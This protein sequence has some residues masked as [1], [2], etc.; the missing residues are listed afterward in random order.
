MIRSIVWLCQKGYKIGTFAWCSDHSTMDGP[1]GHQG[2]WAVDI[3]AIDGIAIN[4]DTLQCRK[5]VLQVAGLLHDANMPI[6]P[7]QLISG[8]Y[9]NHR[10]MACS[11]LSLPHADSYYTSA[12]MAEHCNHIHV[13]YGVRKADGT[14][15]G[16]NTDA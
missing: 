8:G 16:H 13:G 4:T 1:T 3:S 7:R 2:G 6:K 15:H 5:L 9:G 11:A 14:M 12:V 10:D